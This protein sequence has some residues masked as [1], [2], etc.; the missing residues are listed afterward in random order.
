MAEAKRQRPLSPHLQIYRWPVTMATSITH[1]ATGMAL[2]I[3]ALF[4]TWWLVALAYG[5]DAYASFQSV[6]NS[7]IGTLVLVGYTWALIYH[8]C[9]GMRH[10]QWDMGG[11]LEN[12]TAERSGIIVY[13]ASVLLT[14]AV[15]LFLV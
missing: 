2:Y 1:R 14:A 5:A 11:L 3:G 8:L 7:W 13:I 10:L 6:A 4:L 9:N 15:W 12:V